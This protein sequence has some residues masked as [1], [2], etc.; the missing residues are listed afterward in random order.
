[1]AGRNGGA[2]PARILLAYHACDGRTPPACEFRVSNGRAYPACVMAV[3]RDVWPPGLPAR[4]ARVMRRA[5]IACVMRRAIMT[6]R[7]M[8]VPAAHRA[9]DRAAA[10]KTL[11]GARTMLSR[12]PRHPARRRDGDIAPY[13]NGTAP[14]DTRGAHATGPHHGTRAV[15]T[16][17]STREFRVRNGPANFP[18]GIAG[19]M[20]VGR[21]VPIAPPG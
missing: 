12:A 1:M 14:R 18:C 17:R 20:A 16:P 10:C 6:L 4:A 8:R 7:R 13:R 2:P 3:G 15:R 5:N 9:A 21:D 19:V 11:S